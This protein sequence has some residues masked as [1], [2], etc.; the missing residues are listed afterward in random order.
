MDEGVKGLFQGV[1]CV[2]VLILVLVLSLVWCFCVI[3]ASMGRER[4][5][6][7]T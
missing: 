2:Y 4:E 1:F 3:A 6:V 5:T 7:W